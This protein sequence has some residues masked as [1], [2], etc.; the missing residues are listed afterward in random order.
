MCLRTAAVFRRA[1]SR[2]AFN[3]AVKTK[4]EKAA[5]DSVCQVLCRLTQWCEDFPFVKWQLEA[6]PGEMDASYG[7]FCIHICWK[8]TDVTAII[9]SEPHSEGWQ[10]PAGSR[11]FPQLTDQQK[12]HLCNIPGQTPETPKALWIVEVVLNVRGVFQH[13][14][15][16]HRTVGVA[17][18]DRKR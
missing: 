1:V 17:R 3:L 11:L 7:L 16:I 12:V 8:F 2:G 10:I 9:K 6:S 5:S 4:R 13:L 15:R 14:H 18:R